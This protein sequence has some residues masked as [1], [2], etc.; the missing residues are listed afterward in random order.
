MAAATARDGFLARGSLAS[1]LF[2]CVRW[3]LQD[4]APSEK[5]FVGADCDLCKTPSE[6]V[7]ITSAAVSCKLHAP[8]RAPLPR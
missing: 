4:D 2:S 5:M 3:K 8:P 7:M 1:R 6:W